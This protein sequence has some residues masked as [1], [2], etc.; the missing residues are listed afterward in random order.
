MLFT[1]FKYSFFARLF[2]PT[3]RVLS[4]S[5]FSPYFGLIREFSLVLLRFL[6]ILCVLSPFGTILVSKS[7]INFRKIGGE[8][9][10]F[11]SVSDTWLIYSSAGFDV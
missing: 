2:S 1:V 8:K 6:C 7:G 11:F 9:L 3:L 10:L 5:Y 4:H